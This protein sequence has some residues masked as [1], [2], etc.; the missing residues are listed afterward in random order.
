MSWTYDEAALELPLNMV[1]FK[2]GDT[3]TNDQQLSDEA[4]TSLLALHDNT[5]AAAV[6]AAKA[7]GAKY[8]RFGAAEEAEAFSELADEIASDGAPAYL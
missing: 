3:D 4:I 8:R 6:A 2:T 5:K 1:R 7:I